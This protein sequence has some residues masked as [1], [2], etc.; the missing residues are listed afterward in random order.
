MPK[1]TIIDGNDEIELSTAPKENIKAYM[2]KGEPGT[3]GI[4]PTATISKTGD[5]ATVTV[6]DKNGVT[7]A[8]I[9]DGFSPIVD[10]S[11]QNR[12]TTISI[13]DSN[14]TETATIYDGL[15]LTG[16][17]PTNG[18]I[19]FDGAVADIPNG[20][21]ITTDPFPGAGSITVHDSY[22]ASTTE[23]YSS[24]Y[25]NTQIDNL[26]GLNEYSSS[27]QLIGKWVNGEN[28]YRC[29]YSKNDTF[30]NTTI[31][32]GTLSTNYRVRFA[33]AVFYNTN[34]S[35]EYIMSNASSSII[36]DGNNL[37]INTTAGWG[38]GIVEC[39]VYY[40]K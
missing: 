7:E 35:N 16:G 26:N 5:V 19:G 25:V 33:T 39:V 23:P 36:H 4:S 38:A 29:V 14:G 27:E 18:V 20:Y 8:D 6:T 9:I 1:I 17:V 40:T 13:T 2:V 37:N 15:D 32:L 30:S 24:N 31:T 28:L 11:K 3:D 10:V 22:S 21:E 34:N 12:V